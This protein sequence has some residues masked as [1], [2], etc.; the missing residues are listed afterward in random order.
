MQRAA[1]PFDVRLVMT[2]ELPE[3]ITWQSTGHLAQPEHLGHH[4]KHHEPAI[5]IDRSEPLRGAGD[6]FENVSVP[7]SGCIAESR[8][9]VVMGMASCD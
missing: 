8:E 3:A 2:Q 4:Q 5:G 7:A 6:G 1:H 9:D